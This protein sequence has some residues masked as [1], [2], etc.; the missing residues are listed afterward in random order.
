MAPPPGITN[1][2]GTIQALRGQE[3]TLQGQL[4]QMKT[5]FGP[6]YPK[7][8]E[9]QANINGLQNSI[10]QEIS[11]ISQRARTITRLP[12]KH[13]K[14]RKRIITNRRSRPTR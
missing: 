12:I 1:S 13:G 5:K 9:V 7:I 14:T 6:G 4:D 11:R 10:Q 8:D 2:L 3:A